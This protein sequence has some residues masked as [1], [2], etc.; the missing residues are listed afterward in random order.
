MGYKEPQTRRT[1][2]E[3]MAPHKPK[4]QLVT[5]N[6][7]RQQV[8]IA[9]AIDI[10]RIVMDL[11]WGPHIDWKLHSYPDTDWYNNSI[12]HVEA[13]HGEH[14]DTV[15]K[16]VKFKI[17]FGKYLYDTGGG[18][19]ELSNCR[20]SAQASDTS[21]GEFTN[22]DNRGGDSKIDID[23]TKSVE[24]GTDV[25]TT[26]DE[27]VQISSSLTLEAGTDIA[28]ASA[29]LE[30]TFGI[31]KSK[32]E[33]KHETTQ[34]SVEVSGSVPKGNWERVVYTVG[35]STTICDVRMSGLVDWAD[36]QIEWPN[37][38]TS[39]I[40][41]PDGHGGWH[42]WS[43][44]RH[45]LIPWNNNQQIMINSEW[46]DY[47][48]P[49]NDF[50]VSLLKLTQIDDLLRIFNGT[51]SRCTGCN[52]LSFSNDAKAAFA[53]L[54]DPRS[55]HVS[56]RGTQT[57]HARADAG[58]EF[59]DVTKFSGKCLSQFSQKGITVTELKACDDNS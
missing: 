54:S 50:K 45:D 10:G 11:A 56:W 5:L 3:I 36:I 6:Y 28:K 7:L 4:P 30:S 59:V 47:H 34:A 26:L 41:D 16:D 8:D 53:K 20:T 25:S 58:Y 19:F 39:E 49:N 46:L 43:S 9:R 55:R 32:T 33:D 12:I 22:F 52:H 21:T 18:G 2:A 42:V 37:I 27:S 44:T 17:Y 40:R 38:Y 29:T 48:V 15:T 24:E 31:D 51:T 35:P 57:T 13:H 14:Q 23:F 1:I